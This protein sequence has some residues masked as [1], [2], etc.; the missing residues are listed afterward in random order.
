M[1]VQRKQ[2]REIKKKLYCINGDTP[3]RKTIFVK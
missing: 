1:E 3:E 2:L